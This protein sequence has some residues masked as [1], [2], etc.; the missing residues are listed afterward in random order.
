[1]AAPRL[2]TEAQTV[3]SKAA[4]VYQTVEDLTQLQTGRMR[5]L[6][7]GSCHLKARDAFLKAEQDF[8]VDGEQIHLG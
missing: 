4:N 7:E 3:V 1:M 8:K 5:T 6:V 2:E